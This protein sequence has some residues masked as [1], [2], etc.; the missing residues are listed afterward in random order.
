MNTNAKI[1][2]RIKERRLSLGMS[3]EELATKTGYTSANKKSTISKIENGKNDLTRTKITIFAKALNTTE[4]YLMEWTDN[5]DLTHEQILELERQ[6][7]LNIP[8][9]VPHVV[10]ASTI[11][12]DDKPVILHTY[13]NKKKDILLKTI[14]ENEIPDD[15]LDAVNTIIAPYKK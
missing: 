14:Q 11:T 2:T 10:A 1:G 8:Y 5:P 13:G 7:K 12:T 3:Q 4:A 9:V 6:G 15:I